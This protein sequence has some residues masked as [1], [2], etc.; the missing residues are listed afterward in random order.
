MG[1]VLSSYIAMQRVEFE[2]HLKRPTSTIRQNLA[3]HAPMN[4]LGCLMECLLGL[5]RAGDVVVISLRVTIGAEQNQLKWERTFDG[6]PLRSVQ[7][8]EDGILIESFYPIRFG[9]TGAKSF[10]DLVTTN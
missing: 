9:L 2:Y 3:S 7:S 6:S 8:L 1:A 5:P 10:R 4:R